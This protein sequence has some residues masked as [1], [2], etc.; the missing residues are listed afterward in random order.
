[1][2]EANLATGTT[3]GKHITGAPATTE[4][5]SAASPEL[6]QNAIDRRIVR[7]R[8]MSTPIDQL[9]RCA[10]SRRAT[11]MTVEYYSVDTKLT[12]AKLTSDQNDQDGTERGDG[13]YSYTL[14]TD[15]DNIFDVSETIL[16]PEVTGGT[17]N[18]N[19]SGPLVLYVLSR[20]QDGGIEVIP[21]NGVTTSGMDGHENSLPQMSKGTRLVRMGRAATELDVQTA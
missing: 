1:M 21:L 17:A 2:N 4:N 8:P 18:G 10:H 5:I 19:P 6:L 15:A 14:H 20:P 13:L 3:G 7:V 16:V 9:T 12:E 11:G